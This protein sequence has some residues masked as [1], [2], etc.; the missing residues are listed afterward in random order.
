MKWIDLPPVWLL[1]CAFVAWNWRWPVAWEGTLWLG[2]ICIAVAAA[3]FLA[4]VLE[5]RRARTTIVPHQMPNALITGGIFK[6][7]RNP[8]YL[9][10]LLVL[11]GLAL[12]WGSVPGLLFVPVLG[13]LLQKRFILPEE[14]RLAEAFGTAFEEYTRGTRR[15]A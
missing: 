13:A 5:F 10:D 15:W 1:V 7:T 6:F 11:A 9:A 2:V 8:I 4:A 12:I 14:E 3:L